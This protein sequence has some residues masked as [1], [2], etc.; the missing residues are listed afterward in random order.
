[1]PVYLADPPSPTDPRFSEWRDQLKTLFEGTGEFEL[2]TQIYP[3]EADYL[4]GLTP[5][6]S[7]DAFDRWATSDSCEV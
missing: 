4:D 7:L 3:F 5:Q 2:A 1:M 6:Q